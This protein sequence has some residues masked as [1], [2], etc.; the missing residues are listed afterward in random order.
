MAL[1]I[2]ETPV[3]RGKEAEEF[4]RRMDAA[5]H[6]KVSREEYERAEK[7]YHEVMQAQKAVS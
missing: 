4:S 3:L 2:M 7:T 1:P 6:E 5:E